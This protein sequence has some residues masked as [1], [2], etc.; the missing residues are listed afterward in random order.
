MAMRNEQV[1][2]QTSARAKPPI[3]YLTENGF[4][5]VRRSDVDPSF[6]MDGPEHCFIVRDTDGYELEIT[7]DILPGVVAEIIHRTRGRLS[8]AS[9]YWINCAE[10]HL[11]AYLWEHDDCPPNGSLQV[12][13]LTLDDLDLA[14]RWERGQQRLNR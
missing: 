2:T 8:L 14:T 13:Q 4:S 3:E 1:I 5:I 12:D 9:S 7:V 11:A 10:L 6:S